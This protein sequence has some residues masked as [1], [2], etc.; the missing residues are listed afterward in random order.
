MGLGKPLGSGWKPGESLLTDT[1]PLPEPWGQRKRVMCA[2]QGRKGLS[3]GLT[4][5]AAAQA[6]G[7]LPAPGWGGPGALAWKDLALCP[8]LSSRRRARSSS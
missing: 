8:A 7:W 1:P 2:G 5:P 4:R 6:P 3:L